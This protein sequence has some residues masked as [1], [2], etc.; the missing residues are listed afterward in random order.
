[1]IRHGLPKSTVAP[2]ASW[3]ERTLMPASRSGRQTC[4]RLAKSELL[5]HLMLLKTFALT[6]MTSMPEDLPQPPQSIPKLFYP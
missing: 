4:W 2:E 3:P 1:M 5:G 6:T